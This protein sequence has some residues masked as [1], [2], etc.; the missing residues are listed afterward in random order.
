MGC[1]YCADIESKCVRD[2][3]RECC[4]CGRELMERVME[5]SAFVK[6]QRERERERL[7]EENKELRKKCEELTRN[8]QVRIE[9]REVERIVRKPVGVL[10]KLQKR[11]EGLVENQK[12]VMEALENLNQLSMWPHE[13]ERRWDPDYEGEG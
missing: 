3:C 6:E 10:E 9:Y 8:Q 11:I 2:R 1:N 7:I 4:S 5:E 12:V 13:Y